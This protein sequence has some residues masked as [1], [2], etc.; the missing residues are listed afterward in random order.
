MR[1]W[2]P[3]PAGGDVVWGS[4][5]RTE[6]WMAPWK[7]PSE[8]QSRVPSKVLSEEPSRVPSA[9][10]S[11]VPSKAPTKAPTPRLRI[12]SPPG[13]PPGGG[14][15]GPRAKR[16]PAGRQAGAGGGPGEEERPAVLRLEGGVRARGRGHIAAPA[17]QVCH[18]TP[19]G[20]VECVTRRPR[21]D[22]RRGRSDLGVVLADLPVG[23]L[24]A[25]LVPLVE[26]VGD[27]ALED[28]LAER[29]AHELA[30]LRLLDRL[31]EVVGQ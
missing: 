6:P 2:V 3:P 13:P 25:V 30:A 21:G 27:E 8:A 23:D 28:V 14:A 22:G 17:S 24:L 10:S 19:R 26:L 18:A 11:R 20:D 15:A 9:V 5:P 4:E 12:S 31:V 29:A 16:R 1:V 7:V